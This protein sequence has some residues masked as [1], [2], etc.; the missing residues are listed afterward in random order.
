M[1]TESVLLACGVSKA[2]AAEF[3]APIAEVMARYQ[4]DTHTRQKHFLAQILHESGHL[5][6]REELA[7][8]SAYEG[9][10]DLGNTQPGDGR[11]FK[12]R[13]LIQLTGRAN[14]TRYNI[15]DVP[16]EKR[17]NIMEFPSLVATNDDLCSDVAGWFWSKKGLNGL[18]DSPQLSEEDTCRAITKRIN[19]GYNGLSERLELTKRARV[20]M[21]GG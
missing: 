2:R 6:W 7:S 10:R 16:I 9:R 18:A 4:I 19:G 1:N 14:Y 13:G 12:G 3:A 20:A 5:R 21:M 11:R 15:S 17:L 8:G